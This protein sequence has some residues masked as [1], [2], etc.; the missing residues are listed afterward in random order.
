MTQPP[1]RN[2]EIRYINPE[3]P[4]FELPP[5]KGKW[6]TAVVPD[7]V[8]LAE[9][10]AWAVHGL[11][12]TTDPD[13]N[14][15]IYWCAQLATDPPSMYHDLNDWVEC[16]YLAPS[17]LL[18][19]ACGSD[20]AIEVEWHRMASLAQMQGPD[21]LFYTPTA[22]RPWGKDFGSAGPMYK[23][24]LGEHF[25]AT[26]L[27][28]RQLEAAA[29]Y[30]QL[31]GDDRW[32]ERGKRS[33][34]AL[35]RRAVDKGDYAYFMKII[36]APGEVPP[37]GD[38]PPPNIHHGQ[39]WAASGLAAFY[40]MTGYE[41]ALVLARKLARLFLVHRSFVGPNGEFRLS[42]A[43]TTVDSNGMIHFHTN[44]LIRWAMLAAGIESGDRELIDVAL[45]GY[46][47]AKAH[48]HS[49]M[50][51]FPEDLNTTPDTYGNTCEICE[52]ADMVCLGLLLSKAGIRDCW[53]D[54]DGWVR[55]MFTEGQ[56]ID[57]DWVPAF[58]QKMKQ[59]NTAQYSTTDDVAQR[60]RGTWGGWVGVNDFVGND[61]C[62][63]MSCCVGNAASALYRV[64]R[65]I[66]SYDASARRLRVNLLLNRAAPWATINSELPYRGRVSVAVKFSGELA[67]R[68]PDW[69][70]P[71]ACICRR[72]GTPVAASID[73]RYLCCRVEANDEVVLELPL[74]RRTERATIAWKDYDLT[75][76]GHEIVDIAPG[77]VYAPLF[78]KPGALSGPA[79]TRE[80]QR[81]VT[82]EAVAGY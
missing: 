64:W 9:R 19:L 4:A 38:I 72:N 79:P 44:T 17:V 39:A 29:V 6:E 34:D 47:F 51:Y 81:F 8:D 54:V 18:R 78:H 69:A 77:G 31:T 73:G 5:L 75:V 16:K 50:G 61:W 53:D 1:R 25:A 49:L 57:T 48:G 37:E 62:S 63:I 80:I 3:L 21:G 24:P 45:K 33:V 70:E 58:S 40:R 36:L 60:V 71:D 27:Q 2:P 15:E 14:G 55:N 32:L 7:T 56:L 10:A 74:D 65:D 30:H 11:T 82:D 59:A 12:A 20:E 52:V 23:T 22:G 13:A 42:H 76:V 66:V 67:L 46:E 68:I 41:P 43:D 35:A 28:G 26:A